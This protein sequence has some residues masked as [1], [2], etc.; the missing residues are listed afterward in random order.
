MRYSHLKFHHQQL[1]IAQNFK[2][3]DNRLLLSQV[4]LTPL[5]TFGCASVH[6]INNLLKLTHHSEFSL[7]C[8]V[9]NCGLCNASISFIDVLARIDFVKNVE[10]TAEF[11]KGAHKDACTG[12]H[13]SQRC[14]PITS[15][16]SHVL[17]FWKFIPSKCGRKPYD[18]CVKLFKMWKKLIYKHNWCSSNLH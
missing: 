11:F 2:S 12:L 7:D 14:R 3:I 18:K 5:A 1:R 6:I 4:L 10:C 8:L 16:W 17:C 15:R 9:L 13:S